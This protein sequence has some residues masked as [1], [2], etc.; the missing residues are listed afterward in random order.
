MNDF[1]KQVPFLRI[2][3]S[4]LKCKKSTNFGPI[5]KTTTYLL[6]ACLVFTETN[7]TTFHATPQTLN[8]ME[9]NQSYENP[10]NSMCYLQM[11]HTLQ[12][13]PYTRDKAKAV[14]VP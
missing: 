9:K 8:I 5:W 11:M 1:E 3:I 12:M 7:T 2:F 4:S 13:L 10:K 6:R 14:F